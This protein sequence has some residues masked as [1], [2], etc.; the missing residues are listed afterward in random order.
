MT[1][2]SMRLIHLTPNITAA[3]DGTADA[4]LVNFN[5]AVIVDG[6]ITVDTDRV[7]ADGAGTTADAND[8]SDNI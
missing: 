7:A 8:G 2:Q 1:L 5:G 6:D 4:A 3:S